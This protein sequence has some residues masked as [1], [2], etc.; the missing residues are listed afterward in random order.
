MSRLLLLCAFLI[1][2]RMCLTQYKVVSPVSPVSHLLC[3]SMCTL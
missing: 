1:Y 3:E 2:T